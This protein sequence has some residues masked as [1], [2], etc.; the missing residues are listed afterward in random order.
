VSAFATR[1]N[2]R[3]RQVH[4]SPHGAGDVSAL[5]R[6]QTFDWN[7]GNGWKADIDLMMRVESHKPSLSR[8]DSTFGHFWYS[9]HPLRVFPSAGRTALIS[10]PREMSCRATSSS[11]ILNR[12]CSPRR[13]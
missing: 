10:A 6:V 12:I 11:D 3:G 8:S 4:R 5:G 9:L 7:G 13:L 1:R 2:R